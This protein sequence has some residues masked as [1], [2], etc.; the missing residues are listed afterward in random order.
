MPMYEYQCDECRVV[1]EK[2]RKMDD[3]TL[4]DCPNCGKKMPK[5]VS[6]GNFR[7]IGGGFYANEKKKRR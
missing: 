6:A 3:D 7:F 5:C 1:E 2:L 4:P